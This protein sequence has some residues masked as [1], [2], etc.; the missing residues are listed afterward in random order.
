M[1][2][3]FLASYNGRAVW[4]SG[5]VS[6]FDVE[7]VTDAAG[8]TGYGAF[9]Q[10]QWSVE[11]WPQSWERAEFLKNLVRLELFQW[12]WLWNCGGRHARI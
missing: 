8:S 11:P 9:F 10:G 7:L 6:N 12:C 5:P 4:M 1:W 2:Y 3:E